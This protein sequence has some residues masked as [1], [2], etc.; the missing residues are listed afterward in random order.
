V[1][2]LIELSQVQQRSST[3]GQSLIDRVAADGRLRGSFQI[4]GAK[5]GFTS[6]KPNLQNIPRAGEMRSLFIAA[7]G[8]VL[9]CADYSQLELRV[10][11][12]ISGDGVMTDAYREG[13]DLHATT[14]AGMLGISVEEFDKTNPAHADAR[15]KAKAINFG[16]IFGSGAEGLQEFARDAYE[17][18][19]TIS[20]ANDLI[21]RFLKTYKGVARWMDRQTE[22]AQRVGYVETVGGRRYR[23]EWQPCGWFS[24]N[25]AL[26][27]PI[28]GT[29]AEIAVEA[30]SRIDAR[31]RRDLPDGKLVLQVHDEFVLEVPQDRAEAA[32]QVLVEEMT[33]AF[34][35][36]LPGAPTLGLVDAHAGLNWAVAK[37]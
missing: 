16:I 30:V 31:L 27:L 18:N 34:A 32:K 17:V 13:R 15:K 25:L 22:R 11:A 19:L 3:F 20:D 36:L 12:A 23:F 9:V 24:R 5:S 6:S 29:A 4:A 33:E 35:A 8:S 14:A 21:R 2:M 7:P 1:E 26:N 28:Q 37:G 10:M